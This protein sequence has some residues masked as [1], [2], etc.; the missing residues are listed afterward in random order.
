MAL[1]ARVRLSV[2]LRGPAGP[3]EGRVLRFRG[4]RSV[5]HRAVLHSAHE[6]SLHAFHFGRSRVH[7][8]GFH[9]LLPGPEQRTLSS[10]RAL[11][12]RTSYPGRSPVSGPLRSGSG[13]CPG[14]D[15]PQRRDGIYRKLQ[16]AERYGPAIPLLFDSAGGHRA[17]QGDRTR[18][19]RILSAFL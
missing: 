15:H 7:G 4:I 18:E 11:P 19:R 1:P 17:E 14:K 16:L 3:R 10:G 13:L 5:P 2:D 9:A 8:T 6:Y 12:L